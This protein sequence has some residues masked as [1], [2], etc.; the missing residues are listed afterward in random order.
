MQLVSCV[1]RRKV[2]T[3]DTNYGATTPKVHGA[4]G[5]NNNDINV[6]ALRDDIESFIKAL[7]N[8]EGESH[9]T[10]FLREH[11]KVCIR[12]T[13]IDTIELPSY[14]TKRHVYRQ[15]CWEKGWIAKT[16]GISEL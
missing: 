6:K 13:E 7:A 5:R 8:E 3:I 12:D 1:G 16:T 9:A 11:N 4:T 15:Y 10:R 2:N 14:F